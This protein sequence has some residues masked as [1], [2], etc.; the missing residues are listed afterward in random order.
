M[1]RVAQCL[2]TVTQDDTVITADN[3]LKQYCRLYL[4]AKR[5]MAFNLQI[6]RKAMEHAGGE[7][8]SQNL[9]SV[10]AAEVR[11]ANERG[12]VVFVDRRVIQGNLNP[13]RLMRNFEPEVFRRSALVK[14]NVIPLN[15]R[16]PLWYEVQLQPNSRE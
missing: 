15:G 11:R 16:E 8:F 14:F 4:P 7:S 9:I 10:L 2:D 13:I 6:A 5:I 12:V 1:V 3:E